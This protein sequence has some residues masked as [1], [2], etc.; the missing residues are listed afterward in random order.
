MILYKH[1]QQGCG[2]SR[3]GQQ[4]GKKKEIKEATTKLYYVKIAWTH[5]L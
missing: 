2:N 4:E 1:L 5:I 3:W